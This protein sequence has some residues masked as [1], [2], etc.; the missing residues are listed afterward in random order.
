[1]T[2]KVVTR[3]PHREVGIVNAGWLLDHPVQHESHLERRFIIAALSCPVVCDIQHQ[4]FTLQLSEAGSTRKYTPDFL[5]TFR[6]ST[7]LVVEVK[8]RAYIKRHEAR[9]RAAEQMLQSQGQRFFLATD[10]LIDG[11]DLSARAMLLM[12]YGRMHCTEVQVQ[13]TLN[14]LR[15]AECNSVSVQQLVEQG[16][17]EDLVWSL[18]ARH[19]CHVP[20]D[21]QIDRTQ[22]ITITPYAGDCHDYFQSW[23]SAAHR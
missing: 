20:P 13:E 9:L 7:S 1:M 18:V 11:K 2:R 3:A 8:P 16:L 14:A 22:T 5:I 4:P 15:R 10:A 12:R 17:P 21:F 6:D 23:F 19:L